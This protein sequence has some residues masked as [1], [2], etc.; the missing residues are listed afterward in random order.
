M[1]LSGSLASASR[2]ASRIAATLRSASALR[3]LGEEGSAAVV[4]FG[5][6]QWLGIALGFSRSF[7][8][9]CRARGSTA[10]ATRLATLATNAAATN[11]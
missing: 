1:L 2:P 11:A 10:R 4:G 3:R 6:D 8:T 7:G 5:I 9:K